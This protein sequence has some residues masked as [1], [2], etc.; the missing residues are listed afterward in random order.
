MSTNKKH[1]KNNIK[2]YIQCENEIKKLNKKIKKIRELKESMSPNITKYMEEKK[3]N[4]LTVSNKYTI[5]L[6]NNS[7]YQGISKK[8]IT[9]KLEEYIKNKDHAEKIAD[10]IYDSREKK[11]KKILRLSEIKKTG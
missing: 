10:H 7:T 4:E 6:S 9:Q 2:Q 11:Q 8:Y 5:K 3:M 1:L